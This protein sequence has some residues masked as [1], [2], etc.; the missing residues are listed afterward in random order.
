V[1]SRLTF[2]VLVLVALLGAALPLTA[3]AAGAQ[4]SG[5]IAEAR[6]KADAAAGRVHE[7]EAELGELDGEL[8][9]LERDRAAAEAELDRLRAQVQTVAVDR[10]THAGSDDPLLLSDDINESERARALAE[11]VTQGDRDAVDRYAATKDRLERTTAELE[12]KRSD[13][14]ERLASLESEERRLADELDRLEALEAERLA[15]E[16]RAAEEA[17]RRANDA[18]AQQRLAQLAALSDAQAAGKA[19]SNAGGGG[20]GGST[21][22]PVTTGPPR[23]VATGD[24]VCPV[25]GAKSFR[26]SWGEPRSGGRAHKGVDIMSPRGT[27]VVNPVSG[28]VS[29]RGDA[30][31][32]LSMHVQ[33]DDGNYYYGTHLDSYSG[34]T[35][36]LPAGTVIGYVGDTGNAQGTHLHFEIHIGGYGNPI[37]PYPTV[38]RYC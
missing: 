10:Y 37:N 25:Q 8:E 32:G 23:Q 1:R 14:E 34:A 19:A 17:V 13:Q 21:A 38:A 28:V 35:G 11:I 22:P 6:R 2:G 30:L 20:G 9:E 26:D 33:G 7:L 4:D 27:P 29:T 15:A 16:R 36:R 24:W 18:A 5:A 12:S 3:P 31:G